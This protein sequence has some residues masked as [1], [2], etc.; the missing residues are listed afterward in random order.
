MMVMEAEHAAGWWILV[1]DDE[2]LVR[3]SLK[4]RLEE[5]GYRVRGAETGRRALEE[6]RG[7]DLV[8]LDYRL[9]DTDGIEVARAVKRVSPRCPVILMTAYG[10]PALGEEAAPWIYRMVDKPFDLD[11]MVRLVGEA[12]RSGAGPGQAKARA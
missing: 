9:P 6:C 3:W 4:E 7:V 5:H 10:T 8:L 11:E 12:L 2:D 1:V